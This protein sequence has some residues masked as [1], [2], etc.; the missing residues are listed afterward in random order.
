MEDAG[1]SQIAPNPPWNNPDFFSEQG[2]RDAQEYFFQTHASASQQI[3]QARNAKGFTKSFVRRK[4]ARQMGDDF[5]MYTGTNVGEDAD[6]SRGIRGE[7]NE[8][9]LGIFKRVAPTQE[10]TSPIQEDL[11][12]LSHPH[13]ALE[14]CYAMTFF[15]ISL[16]KNYASLASKRQVLRSVLDE[17]LFK[18]I[19]R[20]SM[21]FFFAKEEVRGYTQENTL[22]IG[23]RI[24]PRERQ[25]ASMGQKLHEVGMFLLSK[26]M[27]ESSLRFPLC[28][29]FVVYL[30]LLQFTLLS[31][32]SRQE[33]DAVYTQVVKRLPNDPV[34]H[35]L[36]AIDVLMNSNGTSMHSFDDVLRDSD[37]LKGQFIP[38][39]EVE[40]IHHFDQFMDPKRVKDA[41]ERFIPDVKA[42]EMS[43]QQ[44]GSLMSLLLILRILPGAPTDLLLYRLPGPHLLMVRNRIIN[45]PMDEV[46]KGLLERIKEMMG[47]RQKRGEKYAMGSRSSGQVAVQGSRKPRADEQKSQPPPRTE[48][49]QGSPQGAP[50]LEGAPDS[51]PVSD[52][53]EP[54]GSTLDQRL[55]LA[56]RAEGGRLGVVSLSARE[57]LEQVGND[58]KLM[59][60]WVVV[61]IQTGQ[62][63]RL[64]P[65][66][67]T[68]LRVEVL[69]NELL[70]EAPVGVKARL[71]TE[72]I[73]QM[74]AQAK[75]ASPNRYLQWV[76]KAANTGAAARQAGELTPHLASLSAKLGARV[77]DFLHNPTNPEF[78]AVVG[79]ISAKERHAVTVLNKV[80][81]FQ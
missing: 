35:P 58:A 47:V 74:L 69:V 53:V 11:T 26:T 12:I 31:R 49:H 28:Y 61:A 4:L 23:Q 13:G 65:K 78:K 75:G 62:I 19:W 16:V 37:K 8:I 18:W 50:V 81:R 57:L 79:Q 21:S 73:N 29:Y 30:R 14:V 72:Q 15:Y 32:M 55:I 3:A 1:I 80:A 54:A 22:S 27:Q 36:V 44:M 6:T 24:I 40:F 2:L 51:E 60:P 63:Y 64:D 9:L 67:V 5:K 46:S 56:W 17:E 7:L 45:S 42:E 70:T 52:A 33:A 34:E 77:G 25:D 68:R 20:L 76:L 59:M 38:E 71:S 48:V 41:L 39:D 43:G 66:E 10:V